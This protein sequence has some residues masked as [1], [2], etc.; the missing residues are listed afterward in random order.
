ME[1]VPQIQSKGG[2]DSEGNMLPADAE[3]VVK[4]FEDE[5]FTVATVEFDAR[6]YG[7]AA[8]RKRWWCVVWDVPPQFSAQ[9]KA[10]FQETLLALKTG[11]GNPNEFLMFNSEIAKLCAGMT[12]EIN[13]TLASR[14][15]KKAKELL[16]WKS[17]HEQAFAEHHLQ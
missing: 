12:S 14:P 2:E 3:Y 6:E 11:D 8:S 5:N 10:N 16:Q 7:S 9:V 1:N 15:A 4:S 13:S 17:V